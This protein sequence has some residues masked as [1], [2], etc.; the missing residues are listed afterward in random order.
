MGEITGV[1]SLGTLENHMKTG[2]L[3][4]ETPDFSWVLPVVIHANGVVDHNSQQFSP[5][6]GIDSAVT[7]HFSNI[8]IIIINNNTTIIKY[9]TIATA[10]QHNN[11]DNNSNKPIYNVSITKKRQE[12]EEL[13][14]N[15]HVDNTSQKDCYYQH[16]SCVYTALS[17][18][19]YNYKYN[20]CYNML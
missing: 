6:S 20:Y 19:K 13:K 12:E 11:Y 17:H 16:H 9:I 10:K 5:A 14:Y 1:L 2:I 8:N 3:T 15:N 4:P 18:Y 7:N